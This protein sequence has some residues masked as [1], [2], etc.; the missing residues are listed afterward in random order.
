MN[1]IF[2]LFFIFLFIS[3][4]QYGQLRPITNLPKKLSENSGI[5]TLDTTTAWFIEDSGN[6]DKIY[7]VD[8]H[9]DLLREL[10]VR[11]AR[12]KDWE[13][14]S[15]D[16][17]GNLYIGDFGNNENKR[18]D[19]VIYKIPNPQKEKGNHIEAESIHFSYP[20]QKKFPPKKKK[21]LFDSEAF[22]HHQDFLY[23]ITKNRTRP[24]TGE[25]LIYKVPAKKGH[26]RAELIGTFVSCTKQG[27]CEI[28]SAD[29][30]PDGKRIVLISNRKLW[31]FTDFSLDDFSKGTWTAIDLETSTQMESVCFKDNRTLWLSDEQNKGTGRNLYTYS[32][33]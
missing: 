4:T 33:D 32:L 11:N 13:D 7:Q 22:F 26:H 5:V 8:L 6:P 20:E 29:I 12:N 30:S 25:T 2:G 14:L 15:K 16:S 3:C 19:L 31:I 21:L 10:K 23:I 28:T 27:S 17:L 9:G 1:K 18:K 24:F